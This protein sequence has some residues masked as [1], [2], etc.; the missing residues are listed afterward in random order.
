MNDMKTQ[1][2]SFYDAND[3][4]MLVLNHTLW[5]TCLFSF[6]FEKNNFF[7]RETIQQKDCIFIVFCSI[8]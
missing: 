7:E 3:F 5:N 4:R 6:I 1:N 2:L 8:Y